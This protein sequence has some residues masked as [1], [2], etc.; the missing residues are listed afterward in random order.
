VGS[1]E[2]LDQYGCH[3]F[4]EA[5]VHLDA[6][7]T[8]VCVQDGASYVHGPHL[9]AKISSDEVVAVGAGR[10]SYSSLSWPSPPATSLPLNFSEDPAVW[11]C[12]GSYHLYPQRSVSV[13]VGRAVV[14]C[15]G[16]GR[17]S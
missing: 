16:H 15:G 11:S 6:V 3:E 12:E 17:A 14:R 9:A 1:H 8:D 4:G 13:Q 10:F 2:D 7:G 5:H